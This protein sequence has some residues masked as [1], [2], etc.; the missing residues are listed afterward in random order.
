M[1]IE[2]ILT[3]RWTAIK[4]ISERKFNMKS[5]IQFRIG[6]NKF[7]IRLK[8]IK[9]SN[10]HFKLAFTAESYLHLFLYNFDDFFSFFFS[11]NFPNCSTWP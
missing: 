4:D 2:L 3:G 5:D 7:S 1:F 11:L 10:F 9:E 8:T 6:W